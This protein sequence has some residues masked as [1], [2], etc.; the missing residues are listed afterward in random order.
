MKTLTTFLIII[1]LILIFFLSLQ[2]ACAVT[3]PK[4]PDTPQRTIGPCYGSMTPTPGTY[5]CMYDVD[6]DKEPDIAL[7]YG[8]TGEELELIATLMIDELNQIMNGE[9]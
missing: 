6:K 9:Q 5:I 7:V 4:A 8:W 3:K 1:A 2:Y